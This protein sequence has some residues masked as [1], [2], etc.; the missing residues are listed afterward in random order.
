ME[1]VLERARLLEARGV[2]P[3]TGLL[4][5]EAQVEVLAQDQTTAAAQVTWRTV[6]PGDYPEGWNPDE[7]ISWHPRFTTGQI[8]AAPLGRFGWGRDV[9]RGNAYLEGIHRR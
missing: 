5:T 2:D 6:T 3:D 9:R 4:R 8:D 7:A 1:I